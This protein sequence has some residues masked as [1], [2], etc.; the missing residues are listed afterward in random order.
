MPRRLT[1]VATKPA[2]PAPPDLRDAVDAAIDAMPWNRDTDAA[3]VALAKRLA[4]EIEQA[5]ERAEELSDLYAE[6]RGDESMIKRLRALE[7]MCDV[8]KTVGWLGPQLQGVLKEL[9]GTPQ[10]RKAMQTDSPVGGALA[11]IRAG[12]RRPGQDDPENPDPSAS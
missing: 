4:A 9:G 11:N 8:T 3:I 10:S 5:V 7:A 12:I 1:A 2:Y 6:A